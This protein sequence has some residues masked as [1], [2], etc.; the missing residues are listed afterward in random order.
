MGEV[1]DEVL[2][3][4]LALGERADAGG[5]FGCRVGHLDT[6]FH[7][8]C[9]YVHVVKKADAPLDPMFGLRDTVQVRWRGSALLRRG[10]RDLKSVSLPMCQPY[11]PP[12]TGGDETSESGARS[13]PRRV[14]SIRIW[15]RADVE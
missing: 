7:S 13:R 2:L 4:A 3:G 10:I 14:S 11:W 12:R 15:P 6:S 5:D 1:P 8:E 9:V